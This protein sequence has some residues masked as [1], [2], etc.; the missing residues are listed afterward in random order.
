M[1]TLGRKNN[2]LKISFAKT[3]AS[4]FGYKIIYSPKKSVVFVNAPPPLVDG[5]GGVKVGINLLYPLR[6]KIPTVEY[7]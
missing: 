3:T 2:R 4:V 6:S 5:N 1:S 7:K